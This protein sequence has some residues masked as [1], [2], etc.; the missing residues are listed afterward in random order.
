ME[1]RGEI[2]EQAVRSSGLAISKIA[3]KLGK[4]RRWMYLMFENP[5]VSYETIV[6]LGKILHHDFS[7]EMRS[8]NSMVSEPQEI[9]VKQDLH[10]W[11]EKYYTLL[12]EYNELLK[13]K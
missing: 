11:R 10:F 8:M 12:E 1:H 3:E 9:Y 13:K 2:I 6:A 4:S 5:H 7:N